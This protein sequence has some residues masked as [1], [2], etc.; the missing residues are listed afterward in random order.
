MHVFVLQVR[1]AIYPQEFL[2]GAEF[3]I[4]RAV[5]TS[6]CCIPTSVTEDAR[7]GSCKQKL[8]AHMACMNINIGW[9]D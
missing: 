8:N 2:F 6:V 7:Q 1:V 9:N 5:K 4:E 3:L